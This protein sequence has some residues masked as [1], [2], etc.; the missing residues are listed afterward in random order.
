MHST[1]C[2]P[3]PG[4]RSP[5]EK[6]FSGQRRRRGAGPGRRVDDGGEDSRRRNEETRKRGNER[7]EELTQ[8][9]ET[10]RPTA[11]RR[12]RERDDEP[13]TR[14]PPSRS[15]APVS[16]ILRYLDQLTTEVRRTDECWREREHVHRREDD[17]DCAADNYETKGGTAVRAHLKTWWE[18]QGDIRAV[19][20]LLKKRA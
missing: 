1:N 6:G 20:A 15:I 7:R 19:P 17:D 11:K 18:A 10:E 8:M 4:S 12:R 16:R 3:Q 2:G 14:D 13:Q 5:H 9:A